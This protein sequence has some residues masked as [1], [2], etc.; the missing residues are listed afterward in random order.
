ML[1]TSVTHG[2]KRLPKSSITELVSFVG[3]FR[4]SRAMIFAVC[5]GIAFDLLAG[6]IVRPCN[7]R[8]EP[9]TFSR[10][11]CTRKIESSNCAADFVQA[12]SQIGYT[13]DIVKNLETYKD[14][15]VLKNQEQNAFLRKLI[16]QRFETLIGAVKNFTDTSSFCQNP[17][18]SCRYCIHTH[19]LKYTYEYI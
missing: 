15:F 16:I 8:C 18:W 13:E 9:M 12:R 6:Y 7:Q 5:D 4:T 3:L 2:G 14:L 1:A 11:W 19:A 17:N 10:A